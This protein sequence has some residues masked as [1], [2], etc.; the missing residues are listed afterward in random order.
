MKK[1]EPERDGKRDVNEIQGQHGQHIHGPKKDARKK[2]L[3]G[4]VETAHRHFSTTSRT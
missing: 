4:A 2:N 3:S 1:S